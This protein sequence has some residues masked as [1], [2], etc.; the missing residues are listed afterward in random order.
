MTKD[1]LKALELS[2]QELTIAHQK[3]KQALLRTVAADPHLKTQVLAL[4]GDTP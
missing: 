3:L 2:L 1:R 4:L